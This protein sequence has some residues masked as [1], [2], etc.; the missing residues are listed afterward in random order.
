MNKVSRQYLVVP[1]SNM[2]D[3]EVR[4][5]AQCRLA[6]IGN[7]ASVTLMDQFDFTKCSTLL[8]QTHNMPCV[9]CVFS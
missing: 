3:A 1:P 7:A 8:H 4:L 5:A 9:L 2:T 6:A